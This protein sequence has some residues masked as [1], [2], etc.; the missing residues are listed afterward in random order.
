ME[1]EGPF[2]TTQSCCYD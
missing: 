2:E 1:I